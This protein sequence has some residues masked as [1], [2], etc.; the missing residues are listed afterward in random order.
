MR[1]KLADGTA[2]EILSVDDIA[3]RRQTLVIV[4]QEVA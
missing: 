3:G 2:L 4:A 1:L